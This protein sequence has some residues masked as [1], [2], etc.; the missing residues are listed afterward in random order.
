MSK[1]AVILLADGAEEM[2]AVIAADVLRRGGVD[3]TLAA[4][5]KASAKEPVICSRKVSLLADATLDEVKHKSFD[6]VVLPG[7]GPGA[8]TL[9]NDADVGAMLLAQEKAGRL[10]AAICAAPTAL[11]A[12]GVAKGKKITSYPAFKC[13]L[14]GEFAYQEDRVVVDGNLVT[15]RGMYYAF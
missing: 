6:A 5:G 8:K 14:E 9:C 11:K 2:E 1:T 7:G 10:L 15:S 3:V 4:V 13:E 12:H